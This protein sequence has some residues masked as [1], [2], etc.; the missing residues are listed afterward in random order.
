MQPEWNLPHGRLLVLP[1]GAHPELGVLGLIA[2][3]PN[4]ANLGVVATN[5]LYE[6][7][8]TYGR[9]PGHD[10]ATV[11]KLGPNG[12]YGWVARLSEFHSG[13][14]TRWVR[15]YGVIGSSV[16]LLTTVITYFES[17]GASG[18]GQEEQERCS[19]LSAKYTFETHSSASLFIPSYYAL[20]A[21]TTGAL[22]AATTAWSS[23][24]AR[25]HT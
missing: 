4:G 16:T 12:A 7:Y 1:L 18:C 8:D 13:Y 21:S 10:S 19:T 14:D 3:T 25:S 17:N 24:R 11:H 23:I 2:L 22:F 6:G 5:G 15:V 20:R 9:Y